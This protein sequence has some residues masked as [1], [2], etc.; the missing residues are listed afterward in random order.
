MKSARK[1]ISL[2]SEALTRLE[3]IHTG[4]AAAGKVKTHSD[5]IEFL[6][7][8]DARS[9][10]SLKP[11]PIV[12]Q[13]IDK[14]SLDELRSAL[15]EETRL[16]ALTLIRETVAAEIHKGFRSFLDAFGRSSK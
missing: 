14:A 6:L 2:S 13:V 10:E 5:T 11:S 3:S 7:M 15:V 9:P 12:Y 1:T 8:Q 16:S 4:L